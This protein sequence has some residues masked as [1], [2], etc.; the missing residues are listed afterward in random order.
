MEQVIAQAQLVTEAQEEGE[1][2]H[3]PRVRRTY[4]VMVMDDQGQETEELVQ[5]LDTAWPHR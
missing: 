2:R 1:C 5:L 3:L 4:K